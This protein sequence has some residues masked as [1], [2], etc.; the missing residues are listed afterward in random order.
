MW[1]GHVYGA[2]AVYRDGSAVA[3]AS[4]AF[5]RGT[6]PTPEIALITDDEGRLSVA[7]PEG[8]FHAVLRTRRG[9]VARAVLR[10][11]ALPPNL[12]FRLDVHAGQEEETMKEGI[13]SISNDQ[14]PPSRRLGSVSNTDTE[15]E[16]MVEPPREIASLPGAAGTDAGPSISA[17]SLLVRGTEPLRRST[18]IRS[19]LESILGPDERVRILDTEAAPWRMICS[20]SIR[21][22]RGGAVGTGW[23]AGPRTIVTA[24]HC[25][26]H[27]M[28]GGWAKDITIFPARDGK[29]APLGQLASR[30]FSTTDRWLTHLDPDFDYAAIHLSP[31]AE[32][33]TRKTGWFTTAVLNDAGLAGQRVNLSG[34]PGDKGIDEL[35][36][37]EQWFHAKQIVHLTPHRMFYDID[38]MGGQ[39]GAPVWLHR[40]DGP[41]VVGIHAYGVGA[42]AHLSVQANSAPR[43][44]EEVLGVI[45]GWVNKA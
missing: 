9:H 40:D 6:A 38:T 28:L 42:A 10:T 23:F 39:S 1:H 35:L 2:R 18:H 37:T 26:Y 34:Y 45:R 27:P 21:G 36:G 43:I 14:A 29:R 4:F 3:G 32:E 44:T 22:Q 7:L 12:L 17:P 30:R 19:A 5:E 8:V 33:I 24:G 20:L 25:V 13:A 11:D 31:E 16:G 41:K 15:I